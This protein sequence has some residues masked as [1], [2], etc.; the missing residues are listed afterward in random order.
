M[1]FGKGIKR[2]RK[3]KEEEAGKKE[4]DGLYK[5]NSV[6]AWLQLSIG[7]PHTNSIAA[8]STRIYSIL[9]REK[10]EERKRGREGEGRKERK[11]MA[12]MA[13]FDHS[14]AADALS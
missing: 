6:A 9:Q 8:R 2:G 12:S 7:R 1:P 14:L 3:E 5:N 10:E 11:K 13:S 4:G